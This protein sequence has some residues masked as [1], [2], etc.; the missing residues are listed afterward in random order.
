M[1][2]TPPGTPSKGHY[3]GAALSAAAMVPI[4]GWTSTGG[5]WTNDS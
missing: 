2:R 1:G 5:K 3:S 4:A